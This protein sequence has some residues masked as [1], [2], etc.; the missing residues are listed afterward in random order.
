LVLLPTGEVGGAG[1]VEQLSVHLDGR[2]A[3]ATP[4]AGLER[5]RALL[6]H[7]RAEPVEIDGV[8]ALFRDL[9]REIDREP[10]RVVE[11]ERALARHVT[12]AEQVVE[13]VEA[14][15]ERLPEPFLLPL[16]RARHVVMALDDLRVR[17]S[18]RGDGRID[19]LTRDEA[20]TAEQE[21]MA[22]RTPDD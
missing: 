19:E 15:L 22:H 21:R 2:G 1:V 11:E 17:V 9:A 18:H 5:A 4:L 6:V 16:H 3:P 20:V 13:H 12:T 10:E 14:A 7:A 8:P